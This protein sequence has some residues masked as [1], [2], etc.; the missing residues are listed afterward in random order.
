MEPLIPL[1]ALALYSQGT[2]DPQAHAAS[3]PAAELF[4]QRRL[5]KHLR[6]GE[7]MAEDFLRLRYPCYWHYNILYG[8]KASGRWRFPGREEALPGHQSTCKW[9]FAGQLG[10]HEQKTYESL[11]YD[12]RPL[13]SQSFSS[14]GEVT[15][16]KAQEGL[17]KA[18]TGLLSKKNKGSQY[19]HTPLQPAL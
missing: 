8:L 18:S 9:L 7:V 15:E 19:S 4:L 12:R 11:C 5:F 10:R 16:E 17:P 6:D 13:C 2:G 1:R 14:A 3:M